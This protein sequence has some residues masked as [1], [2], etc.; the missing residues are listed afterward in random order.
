LPKNVLLYMKPLHN[1]CAPHTMY[2]RYICGAHF[3][4]YITTIWIGTTM[5]IVLN[6]CKLN[7]RELNTR[8]Q[9]RYD[10]I[11]TCL[12]GV[13]FR[14]APDTYPAG[15][16]GLFLFQVSG[17]IP[18]CTAGYPVRP[19]PDIRPDIRLMFCWSI[20]LFSY[21]YSSIK[22]RKIYAQKLILVTRSCFI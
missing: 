14:D 3:P 19:D 21:R 17:R 12:S 11:G 1:M 5:L 9:N 22:A 15:Y 7:K 10:S 13:T 4:Y 18:D 2:Y 20:N 16:S 8:K 6:T